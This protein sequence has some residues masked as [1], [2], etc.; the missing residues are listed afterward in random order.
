MKIR[1]SIPRLSA[2]CLLAAATVS[3]PACKENGIPDSGSEGN[4][5]KLLISLPPVTK[6]GIVDPGT[7][8]EESDLWDRVTVIVTDP[9]GTA[10]KN[11]YA[12]T[13]DRAMYESLP[14]YDATGLVKVFTIDNIPDGD[15]YIYGVAYNADAD[16]GQ[17]EGA[18]DNCRNDSD[19]VALTVSNSYAD[20]MADANS[21]RLSVAAGFY[22]N[23]DGTR[24]FYAVGKDNSTAEGLPYMRL[25]RLA[26]K[27]D[28]QWD[29]EDA[30][31]QGYTD[32]A[33]KSFR[34]SGTAEGRLFPALNSLP[35]AAET[36]EFLNSTP[37][38]QRNGRLY[39]YAYPDGAT[40]PSVIFDI[41]A[42]KD[43]TTTRANYTLS[44]SA[45]AVQAA[46]Y[47]VNVTIQGVKAD[48]NY[49]VTL[50]EQ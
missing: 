8:P 1:H 15:V 47:K 48:G 45:P 27:F 30:Y 32:V 7:E 34:F 29:A 6:A 12:V 2:I 3:L 16:N 22:E 44:F 14:S 49:T 17:I 31:L 35:L 28:I 9:D 42:K 19:V 26:S 41:E 5:L 24:R 50:N 11:V 10:A 46:W 43:G 13:L 25:R 36:K 23:S 39:H 21:L 37:V 20:G 40:K 4:E 33:V 18:I 38:S